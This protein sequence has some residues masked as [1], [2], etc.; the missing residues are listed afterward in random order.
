MAEA[1]AP[2]PEKA[3]KSAADLLI[4]MQLEEKRLK[5]INPL[6]I[7]S[8]EAVVGEKTEDGVPIGSR[9]VFAD[10]AVLETYA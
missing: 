6:A 5:A 9:R 1:K 3:G 10:G 7:E 2:A 4:E 8:D